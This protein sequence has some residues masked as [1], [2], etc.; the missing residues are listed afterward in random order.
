MKETQNAANIR[1]SQPECFKT[2]VTQKKQK[3]TTKQIQRLRQFQSD[4]DTIADGL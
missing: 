1:I 4:S 2:D 3:T